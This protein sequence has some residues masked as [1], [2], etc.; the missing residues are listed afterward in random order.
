MNTPAK[1]ARMPVIMRGHSFWPMGNDSRAFTCF[2]FSAGMDFA[3]AYLIFFVVL[4]ISIGYLFWKKMNQVNFFLM[5]L[6]L[7]HKHKNE[8]RLLK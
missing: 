3:M 1:A 7:S 5:F 6:N 2:Y 4:E 8:K